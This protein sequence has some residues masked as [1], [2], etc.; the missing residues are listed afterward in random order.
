M[1]KKM[2]VPTKIS[3]DLL[4]YRNKILKQNQKNALKITAKTSQ[5]SLEEKEVEKLP[6]LDEIEK[7]TIPVLEKSSSQENNFQSNS[8]E[9]ES[10]AKTGYFGKRPR[11]NYNGQRP[12]CKFYLSNSCTRGENCTFSHDLRK[13]PCRSFHLRKNCNRKICTYS[14][15][16]VSAAVYNKMKEDDM[17]ER[18]SYISPFH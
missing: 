4:V 16:P 1:M 13:I 8:A 15:E 6:S 17:K 9:N 10:L 11:L 14:H 7:L 12:I 2:A 18:K 5:N 3:A